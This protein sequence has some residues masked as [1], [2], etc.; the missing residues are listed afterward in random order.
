MWTELAEA[1]YKGCPVMLLY[2]AGPTSLHN[3]NFGYADGLPRHKI[4]AISTGAVV[5]G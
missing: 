1:P 4:D 5:R 2:T 3:T